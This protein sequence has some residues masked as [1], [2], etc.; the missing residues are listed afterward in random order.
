IKAFKASG[1]NLINN[2][3]EV[4]GQTVFHYHVHIIPRFSKEEICFPLETLPS[5]AKA[6]NTNDV[7]LSGL[8]SHC[9]EIEGPV[10]VSVEDDDGARRNRA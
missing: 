1:L 9:E 3:G 7:E 5:P 6:D 4:A 8:S 10:V 2:N